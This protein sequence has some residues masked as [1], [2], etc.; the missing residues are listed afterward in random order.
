MEAARLA[1]AADL[2]RLVELWRDVQEELS[3][4]R[5]GQVLFAQTGRRQ[6]IEASLAADLDDPSRGLWVG[7]IDQTVVGYGA[8]RVEDLDDGS[9][10]GVITELFVEPEARSVGLGEA[11]MGVMLTWFTAQQCHGV[12]AMALPGHR[13]TKNFFEESGFTA[14]LLVMHHRLDD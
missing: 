9:R 2:P 10:L 4:M 3:P 14:R 6:P 1:S 5:G 11:L 13:A 8:A 7:T 12:D